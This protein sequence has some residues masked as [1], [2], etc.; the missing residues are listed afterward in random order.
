VANLSCDAN[1]PLYNL[2]FKAKWVD[3]I[4]LMHS[5]TKSLTCMGI[6]KELKVNVKTA[7]QWRH[8]FLAA[9]NIANPIKTDKV[10]EMDEVYLDFCVKG[11]IDKEKYDEYIEY[12]CPH[13]IDS[14]LR[15]DEKVCYSEKYNNI[16]M[17]VHNRMGDFDFYPIK[18]QKK[19]SVLTNGIKRVV[20]S[21]GIKDLTV[22]TDS[23]RAM[24]KY[25][26]TRP[27]IKHETFLSSDIKNGLLRNAGVHN[28]NINNTM[29]LMKR[30]MKG[31]FG[32]STT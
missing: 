10:I 25:F 16:I 6:S 3:F 31:F 20:E 30:W 19:G 32:F 5:N 28:N 12:K 21:M 2:K 22:I 26:S 1:T 18:I 4:V 13:N 9:I 14:Q 27:D 29:N 24:A 17:C 7:H 15:E 11:V 23:E 8:K